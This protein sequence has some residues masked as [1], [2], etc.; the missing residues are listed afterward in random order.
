MLNMKWGIHIKFLS[1]SRMAKVWPQNPAIWLHT[2]SM[3]KSVLEKMIASKIQWWSLGPKQSFVCHAL[4]GTGI[5]LKASVQQNHTHPLLMRQIFQNGGTHQSCYE[6]K[7]RPTQI[8]TSHVTSQF[9][10]P[11]L[12]LSCLT[13]WI[14]LQGL[15][16]SIYLLYLPDMVNGKLLLMYAVIT[17]FLDFTK[18][19]HK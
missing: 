17:Q 4:V 8:N 9:L 16:T 15:N 14:L 19:L 13:S 7:K 18:E 6:F 1:Q 11:W 5:T 2:L 10:V 3:Q 12:Y